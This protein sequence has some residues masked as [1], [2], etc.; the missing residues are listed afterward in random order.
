MKRRWAAARLQLHKILGGTLPGCEGTSRNRSCR[1]GLAAVSD[2]SHESR[3]LDLVVEWEDRR[4][5]GCE[6][7]PEELCRDCPSLIGEL[8]EYLRALVGMDALLDTKAPPSDGL[9]RCTQVLTKP[10]DV[11]LAQLNGW[12]VI[13]QYEI[14]EE[15][16]R[17]GMGVVFKARQVALGRIVAPE[18]DSDVRLDSARAAA[19]VR[20]GG[21]GHGSLAAPQHR[22]D[23]RNW[24]AG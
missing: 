24:R 1:Q 2:M 18:D 5:N 17:G 23:P 16:G 8:K 21:Q 3:V 13:P 22:P 6:A 19:T 9:R 10:P 15:L 14:L 7:S 4:A 11:G 12:P 20:P